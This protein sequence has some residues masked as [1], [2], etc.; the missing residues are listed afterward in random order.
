MEETVTI[1]ETVITDETN[2]RLVV[3]WNGEKFALVRIEKLEYAFLNSKE[4]RIDSVIP[5]NPREMHDLIRFG[6]SFV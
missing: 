3:R 5:L 1:K 4:E 2:W 6:G